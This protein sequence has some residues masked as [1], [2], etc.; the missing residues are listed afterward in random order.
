MS[1][2]DTTE[3][4]DETFEETYHRTDLHDVMMQGEIGKMVE[5]EKE[6][7]NATDSVEELQYN[8]TIASLRRSCVSRLS[9]TARS[10]ALVKFFLWMHH[11]SLTEEYY[12]GL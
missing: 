5:A 9:T 10:N 3:Q 1:N 2:D 12:I 8:D 7:N 6:R 11:V 4:V